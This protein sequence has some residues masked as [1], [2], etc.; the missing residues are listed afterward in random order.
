LGFCQVV[1]PKCG[2][3]LK[4][5]PGGDDFA[6]MPRD[7]LVVLIDDDRVNEANLLNNLV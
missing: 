6:G 3:L 1:D 2:H 5:Q 7:Y 4:P